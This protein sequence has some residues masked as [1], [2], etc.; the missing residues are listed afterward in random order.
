MVGYV[1]G[2]HELD[3]THVAIAGGKGAN[4]G[5]LTRLDD[6]LVP[7]GFCVTTAACRQIFEAAQI[8]EQVAGLADLPTEEREAIGA[9][10]EASR[11]SIEGVGM[12]DE[13]AAAIR[14]AAGDPG[15]DGPW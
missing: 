9:A 11:R 4:L 5:E 15:A 12:P 3:R 1:L 8:D 13:G 10:R 7:A 6:V 2:L 14:R